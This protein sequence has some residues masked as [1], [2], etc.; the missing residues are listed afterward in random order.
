MNRES[1]V[2]LSSMV[3][4]RDV[5][6]NSQHLRR[7]DTLEE[8]QNLFYEYDVVPFPR[9]GKIE[10]FF[11]RDSDDRTPLEVEHLLSAD[12]SIFH[13][14]DLLL[15]RPFYFVVSMNVVVGY[16]H[17]SD[18]NK[19]ITKVPFFVMFQAAERRLWDK[20]EGRI[21]DRDLYEVFDEK[22]ADN[23]V[24]KRNE[25]AR[26]NVDLSW[27]GVFTFPSVLRLARYYGFLDLPDHEIKLLK[28]TRNDVA[29]S[30]KLLVTRYEDVLSLAEAH[31]IVHAVIDN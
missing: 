9:R 5:M 31:K 7:A 6:T 13:V 30:D 10:G 18:L 29:H 11:R 12:T 8:A 4:V 17:Y 21:S 2:R 20:I 15:D 25:A 23:F 26:G 22:M 24:A 19:V 3:S 28:D 27:V 14:P 16:V 1:L